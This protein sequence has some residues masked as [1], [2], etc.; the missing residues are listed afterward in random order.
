MIKDLLLSQKIKTIGR[1]FLNNDMLFANFSGSGIKFNAS[2]T[3]VKFTLYATRYDDENNRPYVTILI[4]EDR[5]DFAL[6]KEYKEIELPLNQGVNLVKVLKR[7]EASVSHM[8]IKEIVV[9]NYFELEEKA[10]FNIEYYG[11]SL[12]CGFGALSTDPSEPFR[13][14]TQSFLDGY[15][16]MVAHDLGANYSA[17]CVSGFPVYKSR[18]NQ[19]FPID[20]V[21]DMISMA[22]YKESDT[23]DTS[24]KW[25]NENYKADLVIIN[26][27]TNDESYFGVE[28]DWVDEIIAEVGSY[29]E[30]IKHP[31]FQAE[32]VLMRERILKFLEDLYQI[33]GNDLKVL[34]L[35]GMVD[36]NHI[37]Y[38]AINWAINKFNNPNVMHY[39]LTGPTPDSV[40]GAVWH[41]SSFMHRKTADEV[42]EVIKKYNLGK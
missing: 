14:S 24:I 7:T 1:T 12:T 2:G 31:K 33:Y 19:G 38:D 9:D 11:D 21:A 23:F 22:S 41:P 28:V 16:Y 27:G 17:V 34:Y 20:S 36:V 30:A 5:H 32:L 3:S 29:E 25:E 35:L 26:L 4:G 10:A 37:I 42:I 39:K 15:S 13:T 40:F 18:W 8:A 6:D